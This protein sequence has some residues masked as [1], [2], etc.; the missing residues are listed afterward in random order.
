MILKTEYRG[1]SVV[2]LICSSLVFLFC[3][4]FFLLVSVTQM[5]PLHKSDIHQVMLM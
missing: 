4:V 3:F 2:I 5:V 1:A